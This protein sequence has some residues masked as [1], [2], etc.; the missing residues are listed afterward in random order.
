MGRA[1]TTVV[2]LF[3][4]GCASAA[5]RF[6]LRPEVVNALALCLG[7]FTSAAEL[8]A[9]FL[10]REG[11]FITSNEVAQRG[12]I[13]FQFGELQGRDAV[14]MFNSFAECTNTSVRLL[15]GQEPSEA[16][17][18]VSSSGQPLRRD[19]SSMGMSIDLP[20]EDNGVELDCSVAVVNRGRQAFY[21]CAL[22]N[23]TAVTRRCMVLRTCVSVHQDG[24]VTPVGSAVPGRVPV[25]YRSIEESSGSVFCNAEYSNLAVAMSL[26]C[27]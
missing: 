18:R 8:R 14:D 12:E 26:S 17:V 24:T 20:I 23:S 6:E 11:R 10:A 1:L 22:T 2:L 21:T 19:L 4:V 5:Q 25:R 7:Q 13:A 15:L 27:Q 3:S 9:E 16:E